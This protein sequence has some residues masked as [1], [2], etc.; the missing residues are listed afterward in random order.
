MR[1]C[2]VFLDRLLPQP[3]LN[4]R[5]CQFPQPPPVKD[6]LSGANRAAQDIKRYQIGL[7][8]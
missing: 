1:L 7:S 5:S 6:R 2:Q 8:I 3:Y 4:T